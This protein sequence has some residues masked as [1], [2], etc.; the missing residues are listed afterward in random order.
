V[1]RPHAGFGL[2]AM[3]QRVEELGGTFNLESTPEDG[4]TVAAT[5]PVSTGARP[6]IRPAGGAATSGRSTPR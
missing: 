3:R 5:V 6:N 2:A 4:T 1:T